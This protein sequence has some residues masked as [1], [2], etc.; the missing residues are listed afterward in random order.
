MIFVLLAL[1][2]S[3]F[4][5]TPCE[6]ACE[7]LEFESLS[8]K[9]GF[10]ERHESGLKYTPP[11]KYLGY[12][13]FQFITEKG[14]EEVIIEIKPF[15]APSRFIGVIKKCHLTSKKVFSLEASWEAVPDAL[16]YR[17][18]L[19]GKMIKEVHEPVLFSKCFTAKKAARELKI[20]AVN[21]YQA[22]SEKTSITLED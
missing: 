20:T 11:F 18:Y 4:Q 2:S 15:P 7:S 3:T 9:G 6:I 22:E 17:I 13:R 16:Y 21:A 19:F 12:D 1:I 8:E 10:I 14:A 5:H